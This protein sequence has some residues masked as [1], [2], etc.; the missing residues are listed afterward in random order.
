M[1]RGASTVPPHE[2]L[3]P[4]AP[5]CCPCAPRAADPAWRRA[6]DGGHPRRRQLHSVCAVPRRRRRRARLA[7]QV[8]GGGHGGPR[9]HPAPGQHPLC[10]SGAGGGA[11]GAGGDVVLCVQRPH[12]RCGGGAQPGAGR[13]CGAG[14]LLSSPPGTRPVHPAALRRA[15]PPGEQQQKGRRRKPPAAPRSPAGAKRCTCCKAPHPPHPPHSPQAAGLPSL[16]LDVRTV[17]AWTMA[18]RVADNFQ[19]GPAFLAGDAAHVVPPS[20]AR[21]SSLAAAPVAPAAAAG[22]LGLRCSCPRLPRRPPRARGPCTR[23]PVPPLLHTNTFSPPS[24][25]LIVLGG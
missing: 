13:V 19:A 2:L 20:G 25:F 4:A 22:A 12:H 21:S 10:V 3:T 1:S 8:A 11:G 18:G 15:G 24:I 14:P 5:P 6:A 17:R 23:A 16:K 9:G 7:S